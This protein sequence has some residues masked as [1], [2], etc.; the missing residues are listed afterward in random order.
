MSYRMGNLR[1]SPIKTQEFIHIDRGTIYLTNKR[2]IFV[3]S[4]KR[5]NKTIDLSSIIEF[6]IFKD[7]LL[8]GK[9]NGKKPLIVFPDW[10][11]ELSPKRDHLNRMTRLIDR[12]LSN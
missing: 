8:I 9:T 11:D 5:V 1:V 4:E 2:I 10:T 12:L 3:G 6:D 7:G